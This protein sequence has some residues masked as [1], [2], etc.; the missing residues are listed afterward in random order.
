MNGFAL[1]CA[2]GVVSRMQSPVS[3]FVSIG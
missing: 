3:N 2:Q 1:N